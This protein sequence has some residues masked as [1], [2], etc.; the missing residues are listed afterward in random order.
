MLCFSNVSSFIATS[1]SACC[2]ITAKLFPINGC[3]A[4]GLRNF[5]MP[6]FLKRLPNLIETK[7]AK[8]GHIFRMFVRIP[9][10]NGLY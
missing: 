9:R 5:S 1:L 7:I 2:R 8:I 4:V 10:C 3:I 6:I